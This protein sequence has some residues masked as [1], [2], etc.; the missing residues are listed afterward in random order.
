MIVQKEPW[1]RKGKCR[2]LDPNLFVP[3]R[4]QSPDPAMAVCNGT[5]FETDRPCSVKKECAQYRIDHDCM[6]VWGGE[7]F[8]TKDWLSQQRELAP[9]I[10]LEDARPKLAFRDEEVI[11][12]VADV[13]RVREA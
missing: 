7:F 10:S 5:M 3:D 2:D 9:V 11:A 6:G 1:M 13:L 8:S 4:G 12:F